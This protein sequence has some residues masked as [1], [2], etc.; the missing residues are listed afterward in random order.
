MSAAGAKPQPVI[1]SQ[2]AGSISSAQKQTL[3]LC[4]MLLAIT[5]VFYFPVG[6]N[7]FVNFDD[8]HYITG[9][10]HV[11]AG[12]TWQTVQWAFT[13]FYE[14]NWHP[15]T[16]LS[17]ALDCQLFGLNPAGPHYENVIW[18]GINASLIFL[19]L[20]S[21]T[22]RRW[23]SLMVAALFALHPVN[24]ESVA[25]A[26]ERKN[27]LSM[28]FLLLAL[29][30][31][32]WYAK[33]PNAGRYALVAAMFACG[34][35][36]KPQ[37]I[38]LPFVLLL[39][40]YWPLKRSRNLSFTQLVLEKVPL[41]ALAAISAVV[42]VKAQKA[43]GA[44]HSAILYPFHLRLE[45]AIVSY[46]RYMGKGF[47]PAGLSPLYP[48][49]LD[50]LRTWQV[51]ASIALLALITAVVVWKREHGYLPVGWFWF[52]GTLVPM[53]GIVQVGE[54]AMADRYAYLP[55]V[56]LFVAVIWGLAEICESRQVSPKV[57]AI[58]AVVILLTLGSLTYRQVG[59]WRNSEVLWTHAL[60]V[61]DVRS[62]KAHFNLAMAY[63]QEG[64]YDLAIAQLGQSIDPRDD[65]PRIHLGL[66]IYDQRHG[67]TPDAI[68]QYQAAITLASDAA[69]KAEAYSNLGGAYRQ[70]KNYSAAK[71][72]FSQALRFDP[73]KT[74]A[75]V[76]IGL[77]AQHE[78]NFDQ[79]AQA[80]SRAMAI[81]P[82]PIGY[83][84]LAKA[85]D[86]GRHPDEAKVAH[87]KAAQLTNDLSQAQQG[88]DHL[89]SF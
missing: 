35:M 30:A 89:L 19:L 7:A 23:S 4:A 84:L 29:M 41:F 18:H 34:L 52:L 45:N 68:G 64:K 78:G 74:L 48:H 81:E 62:Y 24:V 86:Q 77:V 37:V 47:W 3:I 36:S 39:W 42:T 26:S 83:L 25:W 75:L 53:I 51:Y 59:Y 5:A 9:N 73:N 43:G 65:D 50:L 66:G 27:L 22:G 21:A 88:A 79:A 87:E 32:G 33:K 85:L 54:Q 55:F 12:L 38:T 1:P 46:A 31:Y 67:D 56:G 6:R 13:Q 10:P 15:L 76:G 16:W 80:Y 2:F 82:T 20:M 40:D 72:S 49:P 44:I 11:I 63:D 69:L 58:P 61:T 71:D 17:H 14:A 70:L 28:M 57:L 60:N 8:D